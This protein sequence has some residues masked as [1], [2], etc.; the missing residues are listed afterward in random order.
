[1]L[2]AG[3][4]GDVGSFGLGP[5]AEARWVDVVAGRQDRHRRHSVG[6]KQAVVAPQE[7]VA[8]LPFVVDERDD[9]MLGERLRGR[10]ELLPAAEPRSLQH[11]QGWSRFP[12]RS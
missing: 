1:R 9:A 10:S 7:A 5:Q 12:A 11:D 3:E 6:G 8:N 2:T 4:R